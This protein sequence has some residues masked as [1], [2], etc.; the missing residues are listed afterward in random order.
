M[1]LLDYVRLC[2]SITGGK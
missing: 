2:R 1:N